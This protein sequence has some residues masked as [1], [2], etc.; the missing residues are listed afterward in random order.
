MLAM[1]SDSIEMIYG[2]DLD[3]KIDPKGVDLALIHISVWQAAN[4]ARR[5]KGAD[6]LV[7]NEPLYLA[8]MDHACHMAYQNF[9]SH[10]DK[11][12]KGYKTLMDRVD[13]RGFNG[14]RVSENIAKNYI[15]VQSPGTY[16]EFGD[17]LIKLWLNSPGHKAILL[18]K[19]LE[20]SGIAICFEKDVAK[21]GYQY[22]LAVQDFG[23]AWED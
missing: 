20:L 22:Y 11:K 14:Q 4:E 17:D 21:G 13:N 16:R 1:S 9:F 15:D 19:E 5:K 12:N 7:Y 10:T 8:S 3:Q 18:D 23:V 6:D 2:D